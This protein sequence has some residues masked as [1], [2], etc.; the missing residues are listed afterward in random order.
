MGVAKG[1]E[2][3]RASRLSVLPTLGRKGREGVQKNSQLIEKIQNLC[4]WVGRFIRMPLGYPLQAKMS[5]TETGKD[6]I[7][8]VV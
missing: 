3:R 6:M 5:P 1:F 2:M 4:I 8:D 7:T